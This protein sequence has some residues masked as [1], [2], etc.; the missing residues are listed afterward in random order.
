MWYVDWD[1]YCCGLTFF[2]ETSPST[3]FIIANKEHVSIK[4]IRYI[5]IAIIIFSPIDNETFNLYWAIINSTFKFIDLVVAW[6]VEYNIRPY[7]Q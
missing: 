7:K 4:I 5:K 6:R 2:V 1:T 3:S